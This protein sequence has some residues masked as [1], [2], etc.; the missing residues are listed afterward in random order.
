MNKAHSI[1]VPIVK[2]SE[3]R[4]LKAS[5]MA[6]AIAFVEWL[7]ADFRNE[8]HWGYSEHRLGQ[9]FI[10]MRFFDARAEKFCEWGVCASFVRCECGALL[11]NLQNDNDIPCS[12]CQG[13]ILEK[14]L[15]NA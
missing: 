9:H 6:P 10:E 3:V 7:N 15:Y 1:V 14:Q 2:G 5:E 8:D 12:Q 11:C 4:R 13:I